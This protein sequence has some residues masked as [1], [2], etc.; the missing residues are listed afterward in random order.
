MDYNLESLVRLHQDVYRGR[1]SWHYTAL[2]Q[3]GEQCLKLDIKCDFY[4]FQSH[5]RAFVW[6]RPKMEWSPIAEIPISQ[7][8]CREIS[9]ATDHINASDFEQDE[10]VLLDRALMVI[11]P[12]ST[13]P[14]LSTLKAVAE[15]RRRWRSQDEAETI[16]STQYMDG[17]DALQLDAVIAEAEAAGI[18][19]QPTA[20]RLH[21]AL[22]WLLDDLTDAGQDRDPKTGVEYDSVANARA[23]LVGAPAVPTAS[24]PAAPAGRGHDQ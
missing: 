23:A 2:W 4:D 7:A 24:K 19:P 17:L 15:L 18:L 14:L 22:T 11:H 20:P 21:A 12:R 16:D 1:Q 5:L 3:Y 13:G 8:E 10:Q 6:S 9:P